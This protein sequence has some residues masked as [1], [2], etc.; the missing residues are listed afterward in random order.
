[1][2]SAALLALALFAAGEPLQA[3]PQGAPTNGQAA[4]ENGTRRMV[5]AVRLPESA[6]ITLDGR[7]DEPFWSDPVPA[8]EFIQIDPANGRPA[9]EPTQVRVVFNR[10]AL[11]LGVI[12]FDSEPDR[13]IGWQR[14]RDEQ[15]FSDDGFMWTIDTFLDG[16]TG[17]FFEMNPSG[18]MADSL[19]GLNGENR[20]WDGI[21]NARVSH[22]EIGWTLEIEIP[23]RTLNFN[24]DNDVWG[25]NFQRVVRRKNEQS[26]WSGWARNQGLRRMNN[27][28]LLTG[29]R[30]V[31]QGHGLDIKPYGLASSLASPGRGKPAM[32]TDASAGIDLFYNPTPLLR[33]TF[34][35]NTDFAQTEVDQRQVNLTRYSLFFP[36]QRDFFLDGATFFDFAS[37]SGG[38]ENSFSPIGL[39]SEERIIPFFSRRIGLSA[40]ATPQKIDFGGKVTGQAGA[41]DVGLLHVQTGEDEGFSGD[42]FTVARVKRRV[43][44]QSYVGAMYT[45]R[46]PRLAG[47]RPDHTAGVDGRLATSTFLGDQNLEGSGW[48]LYN[49]GAGASR[50]GNRA[51][52]ASLLYPND[53]W[54]AKINATEVG[55]N[56]DP[57]IGF[58][59]RHAYRKY[60]QALEFGPRPANNRYVRQVTIGGALDTL[61]DLNNDLLK[62]NI[63]VQLAQVQFHSQDSFRLTAFRRYERLDTPFVITRGIT[64]PIGEAYTFNR[65]RVFFFTANRRRLAA[66]TTTEFGQF[67]S[68]TRVEQQLNISVRARP[69]LFF[70][71]NGQWNDVTL[72]EGRFTTRLYRLVGE[73]Q[74]S[75]FVSV[76]N[77]IQYDSQSSVLGWQ[78]RFRWI[79]T[80]GSDLYVVYTHNWLEDP[81]LDRFSTLDKR[82]ASKILYTYRF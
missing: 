43:L 55:V 68:G 70:F 46:N 81:L 73:T 72:P 58:V 56:F 69:G 61:T 5:A 18:L 39:T 2:R 44:R 12:C 59:S 62:R 34:T 41:N 25:I 53:L 67:Y 38:G 7:L 22:S 27:A 74:F 71:L 75:P 8:G 79:L 40:D 80:P 66:S 45:R 36:E 31:S 42:D 37:D 32:T 13:W 48:F 47:V 30:D 51:F 4:P 1:V 17:Y 20:E 11:Y 57:A 6:T 33:T 15:L 54:N 78:S 10:E 19:M 26:I 9:T 50:G 60:S 49:G 82:L 28:G 64:L 65:F 16:R 52:G 63:I 24:P 3:R 77:N 35:V 29:I 21:W 76:T 14:R 23:F